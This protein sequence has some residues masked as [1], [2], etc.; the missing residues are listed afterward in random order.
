[1]A[2]VPQDHAHLISTIGKL[3]N[4]R[5]KPQT[6]PSEGEIANNLRNK[7]TFP[8]IKT[9]SAAVALASVVADYYDNIFPI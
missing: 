4:D 8:E 5:V 7:D 1:M 3:Y 2:E 6:A 9:V